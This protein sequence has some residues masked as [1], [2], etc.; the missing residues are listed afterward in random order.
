E[1]YLPDLDADVE[2]HECQ[3]NIGGR[4][5]ERAKSASKA[6]T[7]QQSKGEGHEPWMQDGDA[8]L[9]TPG[10][11]DLDAE[12]QDRERDGD[13]ERRPWKARIT[14]RRQRKGDAVG[15]RE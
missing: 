10:T 15:H 9:A 14:E 7:V 12:N 8:R 6:E 3:G 11:D 1:R 4:Q 13:I 2:H 5:A